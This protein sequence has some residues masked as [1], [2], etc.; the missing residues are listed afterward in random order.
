MH[1]RVSERSGV[2]GWV[3][4]DIRRTV[5][6]HLDALDVSPHVAEAIL[7]HLRPR[8]ERT[9]NRHEPLPKMAAALE[10]W[11]RRLDRIVTG[12]EAG[13]DVLPLAQ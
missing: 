3:L 1:R 11:A 4:H 12:Q 9:Y 7:G 6:T 13:A 8:I 5:R 10:A 2:S